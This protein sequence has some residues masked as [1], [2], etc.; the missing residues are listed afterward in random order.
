MKEKKTVT[1]PGLL[2]CRFPPMHVTRADLDEIVRRARGWG[3]RASFADDEFEYESLDEIAD[4]R[5]G[6]VAELTLSFAG[7]YKGE[8]RRLRLLFDSRGVQLRCSNLPSMLPMWDELKAL[9]QSRVPRYAALMRPLEWLVAASPFAAFWAAAPEGSHSPLLQSLLYASLGLAGVLGAVSV[10]ALV[11]RIRTR[12]VWLSTARRAGDTGLAA[13]TR[14]LQRT[15]GTL[16]LRERITTLLLGLVL[17]FLVAILGA[18]M[19]LI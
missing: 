12:F 13:A 10:A 9:L 4:N 3:L 18:R 2:E 1:Q 8:K 15:S 6:R 16:H 7:D 5:D 11:Y 17:G 19:G 14:Y